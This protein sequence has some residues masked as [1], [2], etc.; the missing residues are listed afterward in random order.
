VPLLWAFDFEGRQMDK[1]EWMRA[2]L[3]YVNTLK[4]PL[5]LTPAQLMFERDIRDGLTQVKDLQARA[6]KAAIERY[7]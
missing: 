3:I 2:F 7:A 5:N 6:Y 1:E 4:R